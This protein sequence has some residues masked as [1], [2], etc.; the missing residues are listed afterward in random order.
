MRLLHNFENFNRVAE[1]VD[2]KSCLRCIKLTDSQATDA[3][4]KVS[5]DGNI[6]VNLNIHF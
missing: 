2:E 6:L 3:S 5:D 1:N 4:R